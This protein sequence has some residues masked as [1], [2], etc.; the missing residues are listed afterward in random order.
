[1]PDPDQAESGEAAPDTLFFKDIS[2]SV[3]NY[4]DSPDVGFD[5]SLNPYRGCEHG[6][7]Y[8]LSGDTAILMADGTAKPIEEIRIGDEIYGTHRHGWYR[9]YVKTRVLAHWSVKK[10]AYRVALE[11]GTR[12]VASGDHRFLTERGWKHVSGAEQGS[13]R[14]PH[15]TTNNKLMGV[16]SLEL[17]P[18]KNQDYKR[19]YLCG[20]IRGDGLLASYEYERKGRA[21]GDQHQFRLALADE[22][23][24]QRAREYLLDFGIPTHHFIFQNASRGRRPMQAIRTHARGHVEQA[25]EVIAWSATPPIEWRKGFLAG[26]FDAE[27]SYSAGI[28]RI[29]NTDPAI[30]DYT[31]RSLERLGF[32]CATESVTK[33]RRRPIKVMRLCGGLREHL[34]LFHAID[35]AI[36]RKRSIE[37]QAVKN[38]AKLRVVSIEP[39]DNILNLFDITTGTGDFIANGVV[40]HNCYA[41]PTHEY[42]G[43]SS[44]LDFETKIL[45]K[46]DAPELLRCELSS[47]SWKPQ[48][49]AISGVTDPYQPVER[50]L[51]LTRRCLEVLA[52]F[53]NPVAIVTKNHL[54]TRDLELLIELSRHQAAAVFLSVTT[55]E[56]DLARTMEPRASTPARR[57]DAIQTLSQAGVPAGVMVAPTIPGL[58]DH[59]MPSII[60]AAAKAGAQF[61]GYVVLRLPYAVKSLFEQWLA[62]HRPERKEK[63]LNRIRAVR[64]GKLNDPRFK[65]RMKG[66]GIFADEIAQVFSASCRKAGIFGRRPSLST[67]A[68]RRAGGGQLNFFE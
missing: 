40:S 62:Q 2:R 13:G 65:S 25:A 60:A 9:R 11:D 15:L 14:R 68:F 63:V 36:S 49:L 10:P 41:R 47:P 33:N 28:L 38:N 30:V 27:G 23:A 21:H 66:E 5:A 8:C 45:V 56:A 35:P 58:T 3:I 44:G 52:E 24:L 29:S 51:G 39:L 6:C 16:G 20:L 4:N 42:L 22:E 50:R 53:R 59:E 37:G 19:G 7:V 67:A 34:R 43:F 55:L 17:P 57:L 64:G 18:Q 1:M 46:E 48:V 54:V 61:A 31:V 12:L 32:A 26:I